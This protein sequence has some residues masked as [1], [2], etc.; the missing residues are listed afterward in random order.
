MTGKYVTNAAGRI[1]SVLFVGADITKTNVDD[2]MYIYSVNNTSS[3][4]TSVKAFVAGS[5]DPI[6]DLKVD[7]KSVSTGV[8]TYNINS[9]QYYETDDVDLYNGTTGNMLKDV[10]VVAANNKTFVIKTA[11]N[12]QYELKIASSTLL[13]DDSKYLDDPTAEL[14]AG[15]QEGD[16]LA[17]VLFDL[18]STTPDTAKLVVVQNPKNGTP[19]TPVTP[20]ADSGFTGTNVAVLNADGSMEL[21][22]HG[23]MPSGKVLNDLIKAADPANIKT[24]NASGYD[25][26]TK[27]TVTITDNDGSTYDVTVNAVEFVKVTLTDVTAK[28]GV[29]NVVSGSYVKVGASLAL[30]SVSTVDDTQIEV[31]GT[32]A[33]TKAT[34][35]N[36]A[37]HT[38]TAATGTDLVI[39]A[40]VHS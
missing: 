2:N 12:K 29:E 40:A 15:P 33:G 32:P 19:D 24:V 22:Y 1:V 6:T 13:V 35:G 30:T 27:K 26:S 38:V 18:D 14:G 28:I 31:N 10:T 23:A 36:A 20:D 4:Y 39:T 3:D 8:Y 7:G 9:D 11:D 17:Y 25:G 16:K 21:R 34:G 37:T 5:T